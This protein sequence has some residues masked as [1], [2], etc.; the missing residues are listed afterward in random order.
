MKKWIVFLFIVI[1][2]AGYSQEIQKQINEQ[3]W[4]PFITSFSNH[5]TQ[6]FMSVHSQDLIRTPRDSKT[7]L[8]FDQYKKQN[9]EGDNKA[10]QQKTKRSIEL[11]FLERIANE[12]Q[13]YE[14]GVY[15]TTVINAQGESRSFYGKFHVV[16]RKEN[17][18]WKILVD[19]DS[20]EGGTI[21]EKDFNNGKPLE[22]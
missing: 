6:G 8:S 15:K 5:D 2:F 13:A 22:P 20:S 17:G 3:V 14:V 7:L 9:T 11:H 10:L 18:I 4:E 21:S 16:L 12:N 1:S 19:S